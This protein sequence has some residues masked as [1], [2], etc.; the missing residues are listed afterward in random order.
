MAEP[1]DLDVKIMYTLG[2]AYEYGD[3]IDQALA[4]NVRAIEMMQ[5]QKNLDLDFGVFLQR[6]VLLDFLVAEDASR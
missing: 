5:P 6:F 2:E 4:I 3:K 1:T